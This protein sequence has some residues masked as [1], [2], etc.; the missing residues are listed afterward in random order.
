MIMSIKTKEDFELI[1]LFFVS[2]LVGTFLLFNEPLNI[3]KYILF[4]IFSL[5]LF[6]LYLGFKKPKINKKTLNFDDDLNELKI[7]DTFKK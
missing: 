4:F 1:I 5:F 7:N 6:G 3:L 2:S